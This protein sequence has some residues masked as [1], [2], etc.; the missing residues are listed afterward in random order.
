MFSSSLKKKNMPR[1][2]VVMHA[3]ARD[4]STSVQLGTPISDK[5][6]EDFIK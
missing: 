3:M 4:Y 6:T 2:L 5:V 1:S